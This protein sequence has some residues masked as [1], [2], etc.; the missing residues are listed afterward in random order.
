MLRVRGQAGVMDRLDLRVLRQSLRQF[1]GVVKL[2]GQA[3]VQRPRRA[4]Q[5]SMGPREEPNSVMKYFARVI[6]SR[7]VMMAPPVTSKCPLIYFVRL[8]TTMSTP[9]VSGVIMPGVKV[10]STMTLA[11]CLWAVSV[12]RSMSTTTVSGLATISV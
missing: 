4:S 6:S 12:I 2:L 11:P 7:L 8:W 9:W 5:A 1:G 3:Q 10:L